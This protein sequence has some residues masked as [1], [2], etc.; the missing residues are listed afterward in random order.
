MPHGTPELEV[1]K[2]GLED[3]GCLS[4]SVSKVTPDIM[5]WHQGNLA[6][7]ETHVDP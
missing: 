7:S 4:V 2:L 3:T 5:V 1:L 6:F